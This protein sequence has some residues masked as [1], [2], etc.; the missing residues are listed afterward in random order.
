M[1]IRDLLR[2]QLE[3]FQERR[4]KQKADEIDLCIDELGSVDV[5]PPV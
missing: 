4:V 3:E 2:P 1:N 5:L